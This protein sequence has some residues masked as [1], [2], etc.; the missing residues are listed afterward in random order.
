MIQTEMIGSRVRHYS[1][2][3]MKLRQVETGRVYE[4]AVDVVPCPYTYEE[5]DIPIDDVDIDDSEALAIIMG[6]ET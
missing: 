2:E 1:D 4:D 5:M 3:G 6:V